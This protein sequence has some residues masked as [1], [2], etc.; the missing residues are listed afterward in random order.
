MT[1]PTPQVSVV[2]PTFNRQEV[3]L[4]ALDSVL[5]QSFSNWELIVVDDGS[6]DGTAERMK[7]DYPDAHLLIQENRGVSA[8]RN[9]GIAFARGEWI[10]FLDSDDDWL[11]EKLQRQMDALEADPEYRF[12]HTDEIWIRSGQRV[13]P[14]EKHAK[15]GG[16]IYQRCLPHCVISPSSVLIHRDLLR[17]TGNF[18]E[19]LEIC[20]DYDLWLRVTAREPVLFLEEKLLHKHGGHDDQLS[21]RHWGMDR[22]RVQALQRVLDESLVSGEDERRTRETLVEKL[23]ILIDGSR[24]RGN[25][26][27]L[28][29]LE[30]QLTEAKQALQAAFSEEAR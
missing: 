18:D 7:Q 23:E 3:L 1:N 11:P 19:S 15:A 17:E 16:F 22:F 13:N 27:L 25:D 12:C 24:K 8:A 28:A 5:A 20:E 30:P 26:E 2:V 21:T 10:A 6:T 9:A 14:M 4:R 29:A